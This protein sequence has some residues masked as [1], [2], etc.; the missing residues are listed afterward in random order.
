M[1][2]V[3]EWTTRTGRKCINEVGGYCQ[4]LKLETIGNIEDTD[5]QYKCGEAI[6][7]YFLANAIGPIEFESSSRG[8]MCVRGFSVRF[9]F[10]R[11]GQFS[12]RKIPVRLTQDYRGVIPPTGWLYWEMDEQQDHS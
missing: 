1:Q 9:D 5:A 7:N 8:T 2:T 10:D 12:D 6:N 11:I 4:D 3:L